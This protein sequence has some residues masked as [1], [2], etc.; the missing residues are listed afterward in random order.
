M[1]LYFRVNLLAVLNTYSILRKY[2]LYLAIAINKNQGLLLKYLSAK[3]SS[4]RLFPWFTT[5]SGTVVIFWLFAILTGIRFV[6][7]Y[8]SHITGNLVEAVIL[9]GICLA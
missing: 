4:F 1:R 3:N 5:Q 9:M 2:I 6:A 8:V 7:K